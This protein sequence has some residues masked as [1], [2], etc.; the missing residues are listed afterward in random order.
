MKGIINITKKY[1]QKTILTFPA[2]GNTMKYNKELSQRFKSSQIWVIGYPD[3]QGW[4][5]ITSSKAES[6][7]LTVTKIG[8][9]NVLTMEVQGTLLRSLCIISTFIII[10]LYFQL[11][12]VNK[13]LSFGASKCYQKHLALLK[14][15]WMILQS[16]QELRNC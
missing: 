10:H 8:Y 11:L 15:E 12:S 3:N 4:F 2:K 7:Y 16:N 5:N 14:V 9:R 6:K 1:G 13:F